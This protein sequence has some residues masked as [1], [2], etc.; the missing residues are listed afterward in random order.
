M[1]GQRESS[2]QEMK[3]G[4]IY[5]TRLSSPIGDLTLASDGAALTGLFVSGHKAIAQLPSQWVR[6]EA[7]FED[8]AEQLEGY[9][10]SDLR[11]FS[12][13]LAPV[14]TKFQQD[15]WAALIDIPHG[16]TISY[17][18]L[19]RLIDRPTAIRAVGSANARN[20][21]SIV[22]PCHRVVGSNGSLTGYAGDLD[23]KRW[24]LNHESGPECPNPVAMEAG[25]GPQGA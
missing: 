13:P 3:T 10:S 6:A 17:S 18:E 11:R 24:L 5:F 25:V 21:I 14:G 12:V 23:R 16:E 8:V 4:K 19:A 22:I 7:P 1:D 2:L 20:P 15:V 9:W